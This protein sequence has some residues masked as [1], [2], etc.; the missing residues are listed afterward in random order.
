MITVEQLAAC[1]GT[2]PSRAAAHL[3]PLVEAMALYEINTPARIGMFLAN[4]GH[5]TCG[6]VYLKEIW[7][8]TPAQKRYERDFNAPW[9]TNAEQARLPAFERNRLAFS[10]GNYRSGDGEKYPGHGYLQNTGRWNHAAARDRLRERFLNLAVPDFEEQPWKLAE[11]KWA[12]L[13]AGD[14]VAMKGLNLVADEGDFDMYCDL[15]NRGRHTVRIGDSNGWA[16]RLALWKE[17]QRVLV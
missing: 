14:Y 8:P 12:A 11:P 15:I 4:I 13:A 6:L 17:A 5:E 1:V 2:K 10:L 3:T 16:Q 7:G 9:P